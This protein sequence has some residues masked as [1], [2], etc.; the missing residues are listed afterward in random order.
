MVHVFLLLSPI[1]IIMGAYDVIML[2][3]SLL[4]AISW[5]KVTVA[6]ATCS[7][8]RTIDRRVYHQAR[9]KVDVGPRQRIIVGQ[10]DL[11]GTGSLP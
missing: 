10:S 2:G 5:I 11:T 8:L 4:C 9:I 7:T 1:N 6:F 3:P